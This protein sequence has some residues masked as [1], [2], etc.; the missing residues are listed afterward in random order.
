[1]TSIIGKDAKVFLQTAIKVSVKHFKQNEPNAVRWAQ[2]ISVFLNDSLKR[3]AS[4]TL[5]EIE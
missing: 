2:I 4:V 5:F 3:P 1:M